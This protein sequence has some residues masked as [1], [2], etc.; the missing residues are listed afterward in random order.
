MVL[1]RRA[2]PGEQVTTQEH[3]LTVR[4][5]EAEYRPARVKA[6]QIG[7]PISEIVRELLRLWVT[8][9]V[10]LEGHTGEEQPKQE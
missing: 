1:V 3:K 7:R 8:G 10:R 4:I 6:A 9:Q 2:V 5:S